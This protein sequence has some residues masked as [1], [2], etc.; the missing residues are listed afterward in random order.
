MIMLKDNLRLRLSFA[1]RWQQTNGRL[2]FPFTVCIEQTEIAVFR[3]FR[4]L[5]AEF[6][7]LGDMETWRHGNMETW[8]HGDIDMSHE[9]IEK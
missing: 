4:F 3:Q 9:N 6:R 7:K 5:F 1:D 8:K 2:Q